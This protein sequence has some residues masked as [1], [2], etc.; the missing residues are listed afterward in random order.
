MSFQITD[1]VLY[2]HTGEQRIVELRTGQLNII[3]GD[4]K[5]GKTALIAIINYCMGSGSCGIPAGIIRK[6]V[7]W[8]G[9]RLQ[10]AVGHAF[11]A[12]KLPS[13]AANSS[14]DI[15]Y[16]LREDIPIP[17]FSELRQTINPD[18][19]E[20]LLT[21]HAGIGENLHETPQGQSRPSLAA[22]IRHALFFVFQEQSEVISNRHLFHKQSEPFIPQAIKD[23][24]PYFL[25]AVDDEHVAQ[26]GQLRKL[27]RDLKLLERRKAEHTAVKGTGTS[28][29]QNLLIEAQD[30]GLLGSEKIPETWEDCIETLR[31]IQSDPLEP[32]DEAMHDGGSFETLQG[33]RDE[34]ILALH[35][36]REQLAS[37]EAMSKDRSGFSG[38][39]KTH[40]HRLKSI[41]LFSQSEMAGDIC[42][43]CQSHLE[44]STPSVENL[45]TSIG[46]L[47]AQVRAVEE[48]SP[49]M[50]RVIRSLKEGID[51]IRGS[52]AANTEALENLQAAKVRFRELKDQNARR[53]HMLG[54]IGLYLESV[55]Q[56]EEDSTIEFEIENLKSQLLGLEGKLSNE[57]IQERLSSIVSIMSRDM[58][59]WSQLLKLEHSE[60]PLRLD[61][62]KLTV[63]ADSEDGPIPM[64]SMGSGENWVGYH[65]IAHFALHKWFV[66]KNRP[67]PRFLFIDQPSQV[68]FPPD[69]D[70]D[71]QLDGL[72][73]EDREAV[74]RMYKLTLDVANQLN[75]N[76][77]III[78]DHADI[79]EG[80]F[81]DS[82]VH[83]WR[84]GEKLVP[85]EWDPNYD[86]PDNSM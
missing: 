71:G 78:T 38:E 26:S 31:R 27:R 13:G 47:E 33:E 20:G 34:L 16:D 53:A 79:A 69:D 63:V 12:R 35:N 80:W 4:S 2:G 70:I 76:F 61:L 48:R 8:V 10:L 75:P 22:Q 49:Q 60:C 5:T 41:E 84:R 51:V 46:Q 11:I 73:Q 32:E 72:G 42:P 65:L 7:K 55:P 15:F 74:Q 18:A 67:V 50:D 66:G 24:L 83:R 29:A 19:L 28:R 56:T 77:Q 17:D 86:A 45:N 52:L 39:A 6:A 85:I 68:Y 64:S 62:Q 25:G 3:T 36:T 82:V 44:T 14:S 21:Q 9:V 54:R 57:R 23:V 40:L 43:V 59:Q 37:A 30:I 58:S 1:I 81:Q